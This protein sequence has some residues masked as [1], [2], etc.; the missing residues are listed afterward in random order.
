MP[1]R[2]A[3]PLRSFC[4]RLANW[5][6]APRLHRGGH[7]SIPWLPTSFSRLRWFAAPS[8]K[9]L[10]QISLAG[11]FDFRQRLPMAL[12]SKGR[13]FGSQPN[14][15]G[16][17]PLGATKFRAVCYGLGIAPFKREDRVRVPTT[18]PIS[19]AVYSSGELDSLI[20]CVKVGSDSHCRNQYSVSAEASTPA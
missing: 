10:G 8:Y 16:S 4:W 15:S 3:R 12:S 7:G 18:R 11:R 14:N 17:V 19:I 5:S 20:N 1:V 2:G 9:R 13:I 6:Y